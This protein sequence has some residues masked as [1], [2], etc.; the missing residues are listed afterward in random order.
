LQNGVAELNN[1]LK[2]L[3]VDL[4]NDLKKN[5]IEQC[6]F[7]VMAKEKPKLK[8]EFGIPPEEVQKAFFRKGSLKICFLM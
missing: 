5:I 2:F 8:Y 7:E 6:K 3:D 1:L 4:E